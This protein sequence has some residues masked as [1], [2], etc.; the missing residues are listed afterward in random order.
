MVTG[1]LVTM[2]PLWGFFLLI[3]SIYGITLSSVKVI[4]PEMTQLAS[5]IFS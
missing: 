4:V 2:E 1:P 5:R 3:F